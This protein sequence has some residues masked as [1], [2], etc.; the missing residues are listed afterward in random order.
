M[1]DV[2]CFV[3]RRFGGRVPNFDTQEL[4]GKQLVFDPFLLDHQC[5]IV[6]NFVAD[7]FQAQSGNFQSR[8]QWMLGD[9]FP[10]LKQQVG[11]TAT[12]IGFG[13]IGCRVLFYDSDVRARSQRVFV[14][15]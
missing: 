7:S 11:E 1:A 5:R 14:G 4:F 15:L 10:G 6:A 3:D 8:V 13:R 9:L 12:Q 2:E